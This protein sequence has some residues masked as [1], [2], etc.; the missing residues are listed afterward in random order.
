MG[1]AHNHSLFDLSIFPSSLV[2]D[3]GRRQQAEVTVTN[4]NFFHQDAAKPLLH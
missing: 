3:N 2:N 4:R 1:V